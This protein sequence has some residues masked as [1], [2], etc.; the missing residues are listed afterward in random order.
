MRKSRLIIT[1]AVFSLL[2]ASTLSA[3]AAERK[4][5]TWG[6]SCPQ[7]SDSDPA[8]TTPKVRG[9]HFTGT[10]QDFKLLVTDGTEYVT[11][12]AS[13]IG[14]YVS[15]PFIFGTAHNPDWQIGVINRDING[16]YFRNAAGNVWRLTLSLNKRYFNT[17]PGS[18]YYNNGNKFELV[19]GS[20]LT[21]GK[22]TPSPVASA[23]PTTKETQPATFG[24]T[25]SE[26]NL[27]VTIKCKKGL[28]TKNISGT[29]AQPPKCPAGYTNVK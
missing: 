6:A 16:Y 9:F 10:G 23:A 24:G 15:E 11:D 12:A 28:L 2:A 3:E 17:A 14:C 8:T 19:L 18:A 13:V 1:A 25:N 7:V 29:S 4:K 5:P 22:S 21:A 20:S 26:G 27:R